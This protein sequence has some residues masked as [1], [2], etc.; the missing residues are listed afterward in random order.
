MNVRAL[1]GISALMSLVS[2]GVLANYYLAASRKL[3]TLKTKPGGGFPR[4]H[5]KQGV[6]VVQE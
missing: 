3:R 5:L 1:F 6:V 2:S 4:P